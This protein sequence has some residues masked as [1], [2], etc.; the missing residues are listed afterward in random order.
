MVKVKVNI[1]QHD[2]QSKRNPLWTCVNKAE[3]FVYKVTETRRAFYLITNNTQLDKL[4]TNE[5]KRNFDK[6]GLEIITP[7]EYVAART[8][9]VRGIDAHIR[10]KSDNEIIDNIS[11]KQPDFKIER[12]IRLPSKRNIKLIC[13]STNIA[14]NITSQGI[15]MFNQKFT[16]ISLEKEIYASL[17]PYLR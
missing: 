9:F 10:D 14:D 5:S 16:P 15:Q 17:Q 13:K 12:L 6:E 7:H 8:V 3:A 4:L 1:R 2:G 11:Q